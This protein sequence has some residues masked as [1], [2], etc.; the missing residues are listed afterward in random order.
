MFNAKKLTTGSDDVVILSGPTVNGSMANVSFQITRNT[1]NN[2]HFNT[3]YADFVYILT[4][5]SIDF[6]NS[7]D[8][9]ATVQYKSVHNTWSTNNPST[10]ESSHSGHIMV[11]KIYQYFIQFSVNVLQAT[12]DDCVSG[13]FTISIKNEKF[14]VN[15]NFSDGQK[16][17]FTAKA[18]NTGPNSVVVLDG[19]TV[20][21]L[22]AHVS[23]Q[24]TGILGKNL[25][26]SIICILIFYFIV[27]VDSLYYRC[28]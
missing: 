1:S 28:Y 15:F 11:H 17:T 9:K 2:Y 7:T 24:I 27:Y 13:T 25:I 3:I 10:V 8:E 14:E 18:L 4:E 6:L 22:T 23:F 5:Y 12:G 20:N 26:N 21:G 19:P 16:P